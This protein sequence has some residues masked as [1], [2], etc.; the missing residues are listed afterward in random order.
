MRVISL[1]LIAGALKSSSFVPCSFP[2]FLKMSG[3]LLLAYIR[4]IYVVVTII[5]VYECL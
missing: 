4:E 1:L 3:E 2:S 5:V